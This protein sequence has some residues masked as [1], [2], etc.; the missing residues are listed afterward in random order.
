MRPCAQCIKKGRVE[1]CLEGI[2]PEQAKLFLRLHY[3]KIA[4][5]AGLPP[6][7]SSA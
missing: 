1:E 3:E 5:E 7:L 2:P 4:K 6:P